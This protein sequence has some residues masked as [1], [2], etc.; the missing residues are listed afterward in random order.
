MTEQG[1]GKPEEGAAEAGLTEESMRAAVSRMRK[2]DRVLLRDCIADTIDTGEEDVDQEI[3][4]MLPT[5][6]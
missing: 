5:I 3:Q 1:L 2:R 4:S 6:P